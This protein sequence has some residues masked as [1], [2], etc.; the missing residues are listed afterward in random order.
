M[1]AGTTIFLDFH[2]GRDYPSPVAHLLALGYYDG[3]TEGALRT[4]GGS[5]Y[6][7]DMVGEVSGAGDEPDLRRYELRPLPTEAFD[8]IVSAITPYHEPCWPYWVPIWKFPTAEAKNLTDGI[9]EKELARSGKPNWQIE[10]P[11]LTEVITSATLAVGTSGA[12]PVREYCRLMLRFHEM[13]TAGLGNSGTAVDLRSEMVT[14]WGRMSPAERERMRGLA[15]DLNA[16]VRDGP[17]TAVMPLPVVQAYRENMAAAWAR[18]QAGDHDAALV[19]LR[20]PHPTGVTPRSML[21]YLQH[22][23]WVAAGFPEVGIVILKVAEQEDPSLQVFTMMHLRDIGRSQEALD[24]A[25]RILSDPSQA[26]DIHAR[27]Q[28]CV[29]IYAQVRGQSSSDA[30]SKLGTVRVHLQRCWSLLERHHQPESE[31]PD[32]A[33]GVGCALGVVLEELGD[34][35]GA[36]KAYD[37][38][39]S[40]SPHLSDAWGLRGFAYWSIDRGKALSDFREAIRRGSRS[41]VPYVYVGRALIDVNPAEALKLVNQAELHF[42]ALSG[43]LGAALHQIR[44]FAL[45]T[46]GQPVNRVLEEFDRA[47]RLDPGNLE[48]RRNREA[49]A[50]D[51]RPVIADNIPSE[52]VRRE[53]YPAFQEDRRSAFG[54]R[55]T[56]Y[57]ATLFSKAV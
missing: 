38:V 51:R 40:H 39:I 13:R 57:A 52:L 33:T 2:E 11:D 54:R 41:F 34:V 49:T 12:E 28:A 31:Y 47:M 19:A 15:T 6:A 53:A 46:L 32:L 14:Q 4:A 50:R 27:Y 45:L 25:A 42:G 17:P 55:E 56:K 26:D 37:R 30:R 44:G 1:D 16:L 9:I 36:I 43:A 48:I 23:A 20:G 29:T 3:A 8:N 24:Y 7:F 35:A 22:S 21:L 5:A 10:T 18:H